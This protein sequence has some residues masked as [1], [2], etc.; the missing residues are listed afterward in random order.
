MQHI[1]LSNFRCNSKHGLGIMNDF[2]C[3][4]SVACGF[5]FSNKTNCTKIFSPHIFSSNQMGLRFERIFKSIQVWN[6]NSI[7]G[8]YLKVE[9]KN[10]FNT[11]ITTTNKLTTN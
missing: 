4:D 10:R 8:T 11:C 2:K 6:M 3:I 9:E 7:P 5:F 1:I